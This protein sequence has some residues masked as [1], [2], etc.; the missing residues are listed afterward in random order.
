MLI[1]FLIIAVF[2]FVATGAAAGALGAKRYETLIALGTLATF[3]AML[4]ATAMTPDGTD[5]VTAALVAGGCGL[6][7][8]VPPVLD[9]LLTRQWSPARARAT[10]QA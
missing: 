7:A 3:A 10:A 2:A 4:G 1:F 5:L 6:M 9:T 8:M